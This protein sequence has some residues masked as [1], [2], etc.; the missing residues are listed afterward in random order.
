M[1]QP[2][3]T[4]DHVLQV[5][6]ITDDMP[7][8]ILTLYFE[9]KRRSGG[10]TITSIKRQ[11][12][13][14]VITFENPADAQRVLSKPGHKFQNVELTVRKLPPKDP[15]KIVLRGLKPQILED[16]LILYLEYI[17]ERNSEQFT[18]HYDQDRMLALVHFQEALPAEALEKMK[19]RTRS[20]CL[21][22]TTLEIEELPRT[23]CIL[24]ENL[25]P[26]DDKDIV[27]L[28][29]ESRRSNGG[30]VLDVTMVSQ[31]TA[32]V[33][34]QEWEAADRVLQKRQKLQERE[35]LVRPYYSFLHS[36]LTGPECDRTTEETK[37]KVPAEVTS[38]V[39]VPDKAKLNIL[40]TST[41]LQD[42]RNECPE[43]SLS[44]DDNNCVSVYGTDLL[45]IEKTKSRILEFLSN[46]AQVDVPIGE[47]EAR[48]LSRDETQDYL[49]NML[50]EKGLSPCFSVS[51][52][53]M[54][55]T[56][57]SVPAAYEVAH[58]IK[59]QLCQFSVSIADRQL[60]VLISPDWE[61]LLSSL[62]GCEARISDVGDQLY[63]NS[64][65]CFRVENEERVKALLENAV[66]EDFVIGM[67]PSKL[68]FLQEYYQD[69]LAGSQ[70][71]F[72]FPLEGDVTGLRITG[73]GSAC[74]AV[75]EL[76]RSII[77][78]ICTRTVTLQEPGISRFLLEKRGAN[79]LKQLE[80]KHNCTIG[81][82]KVRWIML[83]SEH[84]LEVQNSRAI[85]SFERDIPVCTEQQQQQQSVSVS[86]PNGNIPD[87]DEI[88]SLLASIEE[89]EAESSQS[90]KNKGRHDSTSQSVSNENE[91]DSIEEDLYTDRAAD[92]CSG[93]GNDVME[94]D[95]LTDPDTKKQ[96]EEDEGNDKGD[97]EDLEG[98]GM[99]AVAKAEMDDAQLCLALQYSMDSRHQ[100]T[101]E[102]EELQKALQLS[103]ELAASQQD[104]NLE[105][106]IQMSSVENS[107]A[108]LEE[109][110]KMSMAEAAQ[111]SNSA[112]L[113]IYGDSNMCIEQL[114][115][116]LERNIRSHLREE[117]M[118]DKCFQNLSNDYKS[119]LEYLQR[120]HA[121]DITVQGSEVKIRGFADYTIHAK[122]N[123]TQL[124]HWA[125]QDEMSKVEEAAITRSVQWVRQCQDGIAVPYTSKAC[126]CIEKAFQRKE[127]RIDVIF[128]N[129]P[130]TIDFE[131][132][133]EYNLGETESIPIERKSLDSPID[134]DALSLASG[135]IELVQLNEASEEYSKM[136]RHFY[137]SL[138][139]LHNKIRIIKVEK[140][141]NP[142]L[143]QQYMLKKASMVAV[144]TNVER[145]LYHGTTEESTKEIYV[146][147]F[148]RSFSGKN[149]SVYG[150]GVYFAL[151]AV[152]S[153]QDQYSPPNANG[154]KFVFVAKVL[155]GAYTNGKSNMKTPP[156]KENSEMPL[157]YDSLVDNCNNP[158]IF[159]I[160][161]DTQ[162][163]PQYLITCQ[164]N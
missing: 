128:D 78:N 163:Y 108:S 130:Y 56:A 50:H 63:F 115:G 135:R 149:A 101:R 54:T 109:V 93:A 127:K 5:H 145:V 102:E 32:I 88:R 107:E 103:K 144:Q 122:E 105:L 8:D 67:E 26:T 162:A 104:K 16:T 15:K 30:S 97:T 96:Q 49:R 150:Q 81:L 111:S 41:F 72:I 12:D 73:V 37:A 53:V 84:P 121:V 164:N 114:V 2:D 1:E 27:S 95:D 143:Y 87:L 132:M 62:R 119:Y 39:N 66:S 116:E 160:F 147:G 98:T 74:E 38:T 40:R 100:L 157:R 134:A 120:K 148:N 44:V 24:V 65:K 35:L 125:A 46:I 153:A 68:R 18:V 118:K 22:G 14:A 123:I 151:N 13:Y 34:F 83:R 3:P 136:V 7:M 92:L 110:I 60:H 47:D 11:G 33:V 70:Q 86:D 146:H 131:R 89:P 77:S 71:V 112:Q 9:S 79:I 138:K 141:N 91:Y 69:L 85:P 42:L 28:Y 21:Q 117:V 23:D 57:L 159:V 20:R 152:V 90:R 129:K 82:E 43:L 52:S 113:T 106:A 59:E 64:L 99:M 142:L 156:L 75:D 154:H 55:V 126:V 139:D 94:E 29:F 48:F 10:G 36:P 61:K 45:Q 80:T 155:T 4:D 124:M 31:G 76:L 6:G 25:D 19:K 133:E 161:N 17:T 158:K 137:D 140:V 58:L 51:G